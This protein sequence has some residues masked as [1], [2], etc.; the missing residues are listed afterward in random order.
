MKKILI[1]AAAMVAF[2]SCKEAAAPDYY[3]DQ[4]VTRLYNDP[5]AEF[6]T[7]SYAAGMNAG[8]VISIQNADFGLDTE[9]VIA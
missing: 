4:E 7:L 8:I 2:V 1:L 6:D 9:T 3:F 5:N